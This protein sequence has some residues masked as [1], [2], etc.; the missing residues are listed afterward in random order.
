MVIIEKAKLGGDCTWYGCV[1]SKSLLASSEAAHA[2]KKA[3]S[4]GIHVK[5][6][7][8][9]VD[10]K[11]VKDR[12]KRNIEHIYRE[13]DSPEAMKELGIDTFTGSAKFQDSKTLQ[14]VDE[15]TGEKCIFSAKYGVLVCTGAAP[16]EPS[17][18]GLDTIK[19]ITYENAFDIEEVPERF[20][21]VGGGPIGVEL[22]Q[23]Y[24]RLGSKVTVIA[25]K[26]LPKEETEAGE[27][28][29]RV[30]EQE[31]IKV[32]NSRLSNV[33]CMNVENPTSHIATCENGESVTGD[34][35]LIAMGRQPVVNG[36]GLS[37]IGVELN[38]LGGIK[39][40]SKLQSSIKGIYAAGDCTGE[41]QFTHYAGYQG[42][43]GA[44]NILLPFSDPGTM[45]FV[46]STTFTDPQVASVGLTEE[47]AKN[48][49]GASKVG[50]AFKEIKE[51]DRGICSGD[52]EG[53]IKV[54][55]LKKGLKVVGATIVSTVAG[56]LISEI[57]MMMKTS[58]SFDQLATVMHTYPSHSF[59]LQ[60][61]AAEL[62]YDKLVKLKPVLN[63][64]KRLGF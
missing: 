45:Q 4:F 55:Y 42:A 8:V 9:S 53:F 51:T 5:S 23:A 26:L 28:L 16:K 58:M 1:P 25:N 19:Y 11:A 15:T 52:N 21:I 22:G 44:R 63:F 39:V 48:E 7:A 30:F 2:I 62:Y 37:E 13:E 3:S 12:I 33:Q 34:L 47:A 35:M 54:I 38:E 60:V 24:A 61:M 6:D 50:V 41:R 57:T 10:M 56:E 40:N 32:I 20:T 49:Y 43:V 36:L 18:T 31:G 17:I 29:Q 46:P 27:T 64:L 14:V 59:A